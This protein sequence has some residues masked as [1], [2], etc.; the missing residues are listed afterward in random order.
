MWSEL[1]FQT[2]AADPSEPL[3][4]N[5]PRV[6]WESE[7]SDLCATANHWDPGCRFLLQEVE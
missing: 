2:T 4:R 5:G 6:P 7:E 3:E 1:Y